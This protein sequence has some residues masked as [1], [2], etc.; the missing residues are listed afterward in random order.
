M[1]RLSGKVA[2]ITG[3]NSGIGFAAAKLFREHGAQLAITGR[4]QES[5]REAQQILGDD[6]LVLESDAGKLDDI[7]RTMETIRARFGHLDVLFV[8]AGAG[9]P[10]PFES[11]TEAQFDETSAI[12]FKGTF[13]TIQRAVP[14]LAQ[15]ASIIVT[16]SVSNQK[17]APNFSV[18]AA[19]KAAQ[20]SLVQT[21]AVTLAKKNIRVNAI[22]PGPIDSNFS[23]RWNIPSDVM[24]AVKES[25]VN[26]SPMHRFGTPDEVAKVA[27]F[28]ASDDASYVTGDEIMVDGGISLPLL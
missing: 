20:R 27:L 12:N 21:F 13:F 3:G 25:F 9:Q 7:E 16:T 19:C 11:V 26:R 8:N 15:G 24:G 14:L 1:Q 18:Y 5:L 2:L 10:G 6:V 28:L 17:A 22:S 23:G 4:N